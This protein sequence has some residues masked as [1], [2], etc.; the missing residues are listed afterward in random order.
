MRVLR[1]LALS[2]YCKVW[3]TSFESLHKTD[4]SNKNEKNHSLKGD[5]GKHTLC[6]QVNKFSKKKLPRKHG[7]FDSPFII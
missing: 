2:L 7:S 4:W 1:E 6:C 3:D 5:L